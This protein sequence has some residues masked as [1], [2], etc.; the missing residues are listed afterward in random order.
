MSYSMLSLLAAFLF[1]VAWS[2]KAG[3]QLE[4]Q[5]TEVLDKA[6]V[7]DELSFLQVKAA[8]VHKE[9]A[10]DENKKS[11][12]KSGMI[13]HGSSNS[14][15]S[16]GARKNKCVNYLEQPSTNKPKDFTSFWHGSM[17]AGLYVNPEA[18]VAF[19]LIEKNACSQWINLFNRLEHKNNLDIF[20]SLGDATN[21]SLRTGTYT[22]AK[23][24]ET[25]QNPSATRAVFV[26]DPLERFL[27]AF[28]DKCASNNCQNPF[29]QMRDPSLSGQPIAFKQAVTW[30]LQL[31]DLAA[32]ETQ[33][34]IDGHFRP[35]AKHCELDQ[36][37]NEYNVIGYLKPD[38]L[39][40]AASCL[41]ERAGLQRFN[42]ISN[43]DSR[44]L[45]RE[46][47]APKTVEFLKRFYTPEAARAVYDAYAL[48][49][50]TFN[51]PRPEWMDNATGQLYDSTEGVRCHTTSA[52]TPLPN[53]TVLSFLQTSE[54]VEH[55][56]DAWDIPTLASRAG[57][58][59]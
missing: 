35:Q 3:D 38:S 46:A 49:Y 8:A 37:I 44:P 15:S 6:S 33:G 53:Y 36:R 30:L 42:V 18:K 26:R 51:I 28:L 57:Y 34:K 10:E 52:E 56:S 43:K 55:A 59:L 1:S 47:S 45:F 21:Y 22:D 48:D 14:S 25:F 40:T 20:D 41:I 24:A 12:E 11:F 29:C 7:H 4:L 17:G 23:A 2:Q 32:A 54:T 13:S 5:N 31:K 19:C 50:K 9:Q 16:S 27:S 58:V 39:T